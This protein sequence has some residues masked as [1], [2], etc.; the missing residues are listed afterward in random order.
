[1]LGGDPSGPGHRGWWLGGRS[2]REGGEK[3]LDS[4][5][6]N[7]IESASLIIRWVRCGCRKMQS[8]GR[9]GVLS[10]DNASR[11]ALSGAWGRSALRP[12]V[13]DEVTALVRVERVG[14]RS[15]EF[16]RQ[17]W[18]AGFPRAVQAQ[19]LED[20][21]GSENTGKRTEPRPEPRG[22]GS[23][24]LFFKTEKSH[25]STNGKDLRGRDQG[26]SSTCRL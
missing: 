4:T 25:L 14:E 9:P 3:Q 24:D 15:L 1:M 20:P 10:A 18:A 22:V 5:R 17:V 11:T 8:P 6:T 21:H 12:W 7:K 16:E 2:R 26:L 13:R 19:R 23:R